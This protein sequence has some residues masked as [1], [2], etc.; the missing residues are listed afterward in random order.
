MTF[1]FG[2]LENWRRNRILKRETISDAIWLKVLKQLKFLQGLTPEE[3]TRLRQF[4]ILFLHDKTIFGAHDLEIT[5]EMSVTIA[6]Q[7]CILILELDVAHYD[8]WEEIIVYPGKFIL[9]YEYAD[10]FGV[11]HHAHKVASGEA[12]LAGPVI[13]SWQDAARIDAKSG[14]N[15]VIHEFAHKLDMRHQ[16]ANGYPI[17]HANMS[18]QVWHD[19]FSKAYAGFCARVNRGQ[20]TTIDPYASKSPAEFFAVFSEVFF[21]TP[22]VVKHD[23][24]KIYEQ[25]VLFY[26]Q[27]PAERLGKTSAWELGQDVFGEYASD[28]AHL[29]K[30]RKKLIQKKMRDKN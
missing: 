30:D 5:E 22:L 23:F 1:L 18:T 26:R 3:T 10:E 28:N 21:E 29:S 11:V 9:D 6:V 25:L 13:L 20:K 16:G 24:P 12:W 7:A 17:L 14:D 2:R 19:I 8:N 15:V 27:D 4:V